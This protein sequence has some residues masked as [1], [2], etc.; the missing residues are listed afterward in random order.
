MV[1]RTATSSASS[2]VLGNAT[3]SCSD[4]ELAIWLGR[5]GRV[6]HVSKHSPEGTRPPVMMCIRPLLQ[7]PVP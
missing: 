7:P 5:L 2:L 3:D 6:T 4:S 1:R